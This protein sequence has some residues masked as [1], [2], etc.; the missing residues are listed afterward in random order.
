[1][2]MQERLTTALAGLVRDDER[3]LAEKIHLVDETIAM[4][5]EGVERLSSYSV[6]G[7]LGPLFYDRSI[8]CVKAT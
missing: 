1:M 5:G 4:D 3:T 7:L 6:V 2:T 8:G